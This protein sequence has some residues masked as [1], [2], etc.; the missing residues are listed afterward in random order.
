ME[1]SP[2]RKKAAR[3][4]KASGHP[5]EKSIP[6]LTRTVTLERTSCFTQSTDILGKVIDGLSEHGRKLLI[7]RL[8][9]SSYQPKFWQ[10]MPLCRYKVLV[11]PLKSSKHLCSLV[12]NQIRCIHVALE[13]QG[14]RCKTEISV[15]D[16]NGL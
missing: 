13:K 3:P 10:F 8:D 16:E 12:E 11:C 1:S 14:R 15:L 2:S 7:Y 5:C 6:G 9:I 4:S